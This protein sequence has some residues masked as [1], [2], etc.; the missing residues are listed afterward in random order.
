MSIV[1]FI[2]WTKGMYVSWEKRMEIFVG[3]WLKK[4]SRAKQR[5]SQLQP[6][7]TWLTHVLLTGSRNNAHQILWVNQ[8]RTAPQHQGDRGC[9][10]HAKTGAFKASVGGT[11]PQVQR[12]LLPIKVGGAASQARHAEIFLRSLLFSPTLPIRHPYT[13]L[14]HTWTQPQPQDWRPIVCCRDSKYLKEK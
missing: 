8:A 11:S 1:Y 5:I 6:V 7:E 13:T 14:Y 3:A 2:V 12:P 10:Q 9:F 4:L